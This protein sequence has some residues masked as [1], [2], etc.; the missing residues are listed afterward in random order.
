MKLLCHEEG[1][2]CCRD[3]HPPLS[4]ILT[5]T[6]RTDHGSFRWLSNFKQKHSNADALSRLQCQR[7]GT[8]S[9]WTRDP[10]MEIASTA[11]MDG[12]GTMRGH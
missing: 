8:E 1:T 2:N 7:R 4:P 12:G 11:A 3:L 10:A 5:V 9:H 6:E